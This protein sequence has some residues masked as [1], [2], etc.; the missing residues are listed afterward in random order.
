M[1]STDGKYAFLA[2]RLFAVFELE[3]RYILST[4]PMNKL[5]VM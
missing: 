2:I 1:P 4:L 5:V 3:P